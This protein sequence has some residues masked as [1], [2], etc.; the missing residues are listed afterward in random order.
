MYLKNQTELLHNLIPLGFT[1]KLIFRFQLGLMII[2][3]IIL[4]RVFFNSNRS[5]VFQMVLVD[6]TLLVWPSSLQLVFRHI[7][8]KFHELL[9]INKSTL[10]IVPPR[11]GRPPGAYLLK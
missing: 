1:M 3:W 10:L 11:I 9:Y 7:S 4:H 5:F 8:R 2:K 6:P